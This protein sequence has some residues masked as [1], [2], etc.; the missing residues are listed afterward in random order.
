MSLD[1][2]EAAA[3]LLKYEA[4]LYK[5]LAFGVKFS[6]LEVL[7]SDSSPDEGRP[8][9]R[10]YLMGIS[11]YYVLTFNNGHNQWCI[12]ILQMSNYLCSNYYFL[13]LLGGVVGSSY[14]DCEVE[15]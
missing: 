5:Y 7:T 4:L 2:V 9:K 10:F 12:F 6:A 3:R 1:F 8:K 13:N 14:A 11:R 15:G